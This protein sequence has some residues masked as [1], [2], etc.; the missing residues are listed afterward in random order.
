M[1]DQN[2][3]PVSSFNFGSGLTS[4][5]AALDDHCRLGAMLTPKGL[6]LG[7]EDH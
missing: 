4:Q 7:P 1:T 6:D 5:T 2:Q 3:S